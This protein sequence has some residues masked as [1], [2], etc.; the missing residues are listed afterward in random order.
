MKEGRD[1]VFGISIR[2]KGEILTDGT[3]DL[4]PLRLGRPDAAMRFGQVLDWSI[5]LHG[6]KQE[7]GQI[8]LRTGEGPCIYYFG[9]IGYHIDPPWRGKHYAARACMM[10]TEE[11]RRLGMSSLVITC[12][13]DNI[14]SRKTCERLRCVEER[15]VNVPE[16]IRDRWEISPVKC[17]YLWLPEETDGGYHAD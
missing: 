3:L 10:L 4:R 2:R 11:I 9:H 16:W 13:P 8:S 6:V 17:R 7:I 15:V 1:G 5:T 12:D 14:P